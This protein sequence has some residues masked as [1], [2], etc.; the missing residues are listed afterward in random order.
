[1]VR[2]G[3]PFR[4][5]HHI[6]GAAVALAEAR[7]VPLAA[8]TVADLQGLHPAFTEDVRKVWDF[9]QSVE[10]RDVTGG[11]SRRAIFAQIAALRAWLEKS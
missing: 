10:S 1:L 3:L 6:A 5:T 8:L 2:K 9:E 7:G 11:T 4:E